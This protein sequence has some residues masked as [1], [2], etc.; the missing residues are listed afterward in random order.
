MLKRPFV[1]GW[2]EKGRERERGR[3]GKGEGEGKREGE[4]KKEK[5]LKNRCIAAVES[6]GSW[7]ISILPAIKR[8]VFKIS[9]FFFFQ[10]NP[11]RIQIHDPSP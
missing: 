6:I 11:N 9:F 3:E 8:R 1:L 5:D 2:E 10:K 7:S 4:G